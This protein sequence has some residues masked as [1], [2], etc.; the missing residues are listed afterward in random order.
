MTAMKRIILPALVLLASSLQAFAQRGNIGFIYPAGGQKG[1]TLEV[2]VG[3][4]N[5]SKAKDIIISGEGVRGEL[6]PSHQQPKGRKKNRNIGEEDNLQLAD[7]V[8]FRITVSKDAAIGLRDVRLVLPNGMTNRLYFEVGELPDVLED[9]KSALSGEAETLPVTFNGQVARSDVDRFRFK[10][11]SGQQLVIRVKG[12]E[13]VPYM[14]DAVPGWF[15]PIARLYGPDGKEVSFC[16]DYTFHVDPVIVFKV[17]ETGC[18]EIEINDALYRGREDFVYRIDVGELPF[19]T[20]ITPIG[21]TVGRKLQV[22]VRGY[23]LKG[24]S[25]KFKPAKE[26]RLAFSVTGK[27]NITSNTVCFQADRRTQIQTKKLHPCSSIEKAWTME[28]GDV[29]ENTISA[30]F[31]QHWYSFESTGKKHPVHIYL[32][33]RKLGTPADLR[34]TV[35][36]A[37]GDII[38]DV[39]DTEDEDESLMTHFADPEATLKL[40]AGKYFVRIIESQGKA[41]EDYSYRLYLENASPD[42]SLHIEP[43]TFS[44]PENGTGIFNV[45]L[46]RKQDFRGPVDISVSNLPKG[47]KVSGGKIRQGQKKSMVAITAPEGCEHKVVNPK[48]Q[49]SASQGEFSI[50]RDAIPVESMMQAFY[51]THLMPMEEFRMEVQEAQPFRISVIKDWKGALELPVGKEVPVRVHIERNPGFTSPVTIMLKSTNGMCKAE[52]VIVPEGGTEATLLLVNNK[53][54]GNKPTFAEMCF[55][56]VLKASSK[57]IAGKGR[58][59]FVASVTAFTP[60][61]EAKLMPPYSL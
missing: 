16:D 28:P 44:V 32:L 57:R 11:R 38:A 22:Q 45:L 27:S 35:F 41:G 9:A 43:S 1:S 46:N 3:G 36:D 6:I 61:F 29:C 48:V 42:F 24:Q 39:D 58:N 30:P 8:K 18:Y 33:S 54:K 59:A 17:P 37:N 14:A 40:N 12:R 25:V 10:A 52:A 19:I 56:G 13:F 49:G 55:S 23:N 4:Q 31:Q 2:T 50:S 53:K 47:F 60:V 20:G 21:G 7:Q 15:Q 34:M 51:Y 5:I 26:G